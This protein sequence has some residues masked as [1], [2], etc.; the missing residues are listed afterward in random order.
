MDLD[1]GAFNFLKQQNTKFT[2]KPEL[3]SYEECEEMI[4]KLRIKTE[5]LSTPN[6]NGGTAAT[7]RHTEDPSLPQKFQQQAA[8]ST[9]I[10]AS[11][12]VE[13]GSQW[14]CNSVFRW[15]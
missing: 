6:R 14:R 5:K 10:Q 2:L 1:K 9:S 15:D 3:T 11:R 8:G 4:R 13:M 12:P 7:Q